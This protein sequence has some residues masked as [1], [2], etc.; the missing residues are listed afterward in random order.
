MTDT[1]I[2]PYLLLIEQVQKDV[3]EKARLRLQVAN[4]EAQLE[5]VQREI[6]RLRKL[7]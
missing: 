4:L 5:A 7:P 2:P 3:I 1:T 6:E